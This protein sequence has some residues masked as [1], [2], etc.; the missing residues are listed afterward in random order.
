M[1]ANDDS[2]TGE[3]PDKMICK[4]LQTVRQ[5]G[6]HDRSRIVRFEF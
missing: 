2:V 6:G 4:C 3:N 1:V 5:S